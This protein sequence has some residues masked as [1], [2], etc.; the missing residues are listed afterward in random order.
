MSIHFLTMIPTSGDGPYPGSAG[1]PGGNWTNSGNREPSFDYISKIALAS[2][3]GGFDTL[4]LPVGTACLDGWVGTSFIAN[5]TNKLRFLVALRP[6]FVSPTVAA[7]QAATFDYLS[8]GRL[9]INIVTGGSPQEQARDGDFLDHDAR[10]R[11]TREYIQLT[12]RYFTE[13]NIDHEGEFYR[14]KGA[15]L[16]PRPV[17][18]PY[19]PFF[20]AGES[21]AG[22]AVIAEEANVYM[23]WGGPV[24][25]LKEKIDDIRQRV[26]AQGRTAGYSISFQTILGDT[27]EEAWAKAEEM[28][29]RMSGDAI[30][31][32]KEHFKTMDS[33]GQHRLAGYVESSEN[34][35]FRL[36]PNLWAGLTQVLGGNSIALVGTP[37]QV[38]DRILEYYTF[39]YNHVL[40]RGFPHLEAIE[41]L[42]RDVLPRIREKVARYDAEKQKEENYAL[43]ETR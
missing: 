16:F 19:P 15:T 35:G 27:E 38:A 40:L 20:I 23:T 30:S 11:R 8:G 3:A 32:Q 28:L 26:T 21:E 41:E 37:D 43:T 5:L 18:K 7:R 29:N 9:S 2:E 34:N 12:K 39:G 24:A 25:D 17:Q 22:K 14:V 10:Y 4:L 36:G 13:S 31:R 1:S 6:G 33:V 42:G